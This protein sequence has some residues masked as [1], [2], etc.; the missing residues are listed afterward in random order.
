MVE[1]IKTCSDFRSKKNSV[2][3]GSS[4]S[5]VVGNDRSDTKNNFSTQ[6]VMELSEWIYQA[7]SNPREPK[8]MRIGP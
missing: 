4:C 6:L 5:V 8:P 3:V 1:K 2:R 7:Q